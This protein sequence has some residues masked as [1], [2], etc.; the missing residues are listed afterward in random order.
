MLVFESKQLGA[1][2]EAAFIR[3]MREV[4]RMLPQDSRVSDDP[5]MEKDVAEQLRRA[6]EHGFTEERDCARWVLCAWCLGKDFDHKIASIAEL[7]KR[8]DVGASYKALALE[9][10]LRSV[11]AALAGQSR[12]VP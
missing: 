2:A 5:G 6:R 12:A 3:R 4:L 7:L 1:F 10:I 8:E 11:F 9:L